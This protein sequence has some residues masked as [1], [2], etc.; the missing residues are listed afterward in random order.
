M[1]PEG[2]AERY[3]GLWNEPDAGLRRRTI[4]ELWAVDGTHLLEPP[5]EARAA[6][7]RLGIPGATFEAAGHDAIEQRV[8]ASYRDFVA[9]QGMTFRAA[10]PARRVKN[11]V[12][13]RWD[14]V[15]DGAVVGGGVEFVVLDVRGRITADHMFP[16]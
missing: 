7:D 1:H 5:E 12:M 3:I 2:I 4:E 9:A 14:A 15:R 13:F 16:G 6:A 10:G 8:T 11:T